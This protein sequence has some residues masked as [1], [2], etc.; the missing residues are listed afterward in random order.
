MR[1]VFRS[2]GEAEGVRPKEDQEARQGWGELIKVGGSNW[3]YRIHRLLTT[4]IHSRDDKKNDSDSDGDDPE[5]KKMQAK[6]EGAIVMTKPNIKWTDVA[7]LEAAKTALKEAVI[8]PIQFPYLFTGKRKP[9]RGILLFGVSDLGLSCARF[10]YSSKLYK[11][12]IRCV[13]APRNR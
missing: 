5:K 8:L 11:T 4:I 13:A 2:G 7:G 6:L 10:D 3:I 1:A 12:L 9:W